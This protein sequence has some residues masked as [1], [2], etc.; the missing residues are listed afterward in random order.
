MDAVFDA[1]MP[2]GRLA[3]AYLQEAR[4]EVLRYLRNPGFL[5]PTLLFPTAFYLMFGVLLNRGDGGHMARYLLAAYA[6][7][8]VMAPG[9]FGFGIS[10][11]LERDNGL[12]TLKRALPMPPLAYLVGKMTMA[13]GVAAVVVVALLALSVGVAHVAITPAQALQLVAT[14]VFGA[15]PF[16]ALGLLIGTFVKGQAAPAVINMVYLPMAVMSGLWFPVD[17]IP[18]L[19][20]MAPVWP[21]W[22]LDQLALQAV[23][24]QSGAQAPHLL[25]LATCTALCLWV[26]AR[27][28]RRVG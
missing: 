20:A 4:S 3:R 6:T 16:C 23:G 7:F 11:A 25:A 27:R 12:L 22:H 14:S 1:P 24:M 5:L 10:L 2:R 28:L 19:R 13:L 21:A 18:A 15:L 8:G 9:L 26:A 17:R